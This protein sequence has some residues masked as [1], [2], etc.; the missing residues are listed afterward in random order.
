MV[1]AGLVAGKMRADEAERSGLLR[2]DGVAPVTPGWPDTLGGP[3]LDHGNPVHGWLIPDIADGLLKDKLLELGD[4][5]KSGMRPVTLTETGLTHY[6]M[7]CKR[8]R[9]PPFGA[10]WRSARAL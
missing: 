5:D 10:E 8:H 2:V 4:P 6:R 7:L 3:L 1:T 9:S